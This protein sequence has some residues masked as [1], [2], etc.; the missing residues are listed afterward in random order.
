MPFLPSTIILATTTTGGHERGV[1]VVIHSVVKGNELVARQVLTSPSVY[2]D[3]CAIRKISSD[4]TLSQRLTDALRTRNGTLVISDLNLQEFFG[5]TVTPQ[6]FEAEE[7]VGRNW[8]NIFFM[9]VDFGRVAL[10]EIRILPADRMPDGSNCCDH[11]GMLQYVAKR[12]DI[13][14]GL[15]EM[16]RGAMFAVSEENRSQHQVRHRNSIAAGRAFMTQFRASRDHYAR[17]RKGFVKRLRGRDLRS[18]RA[19]GVLMTKLMEVFDGLI[20]EPKDNDFVDF[21]H[22]CVPCSYCDFVFLDGRWRDIVDRTRR[23]LAKE[24]INIQIA[25]TFS[26]QDNGIERFLCELERYPP[27]APLKTISSAALAEQ[28]KRHLGLSNAFRG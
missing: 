16:H 22:A 2:L 27:S 5:V 3:H 1:L 9:D 8:R 14:S 20:A 7:L 26:E 6:A 21:M 28:V 4:K 24:R 19:T 11:D 18:K 12:F 10:A 15:M 23:G 17:W 13:Y 25:R